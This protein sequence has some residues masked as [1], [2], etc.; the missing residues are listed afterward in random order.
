MAS[1][2][3]LDLSIRSTVVCSD[4]ARR[5]NGVVVVEEEEKEGEGGGGAGAD[6]RGD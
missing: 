4:H 2:V 6:A 5:E 3:A 1:V